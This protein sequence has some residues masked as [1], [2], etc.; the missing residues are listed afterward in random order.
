MSATLD[1]APSEAELARLYHELAKLGATSVGDNVPWVHAP[2]NRE[3][4]LVLASQMMRYDPR[5]LSVLVQWFA[6]HYDMLNPLQLRRELRQVRWP[7]SLLVVLE[8]ARLDASDPELEAF[9]KYVS[10]GFQRV[11]PAERFF[12]ETERP[13]SRA[14]TRNLG[15]NLAPYARWGFIGQERPTIDPVSKRS[16]GRYDAQTRR[17]I[18]DDLIERYT[19]F[20]MADYLSAVDH[21]I[22]RQQALAD[23]RSYNVIAPSGGGRGARWRRVKKASS[24]KR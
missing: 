20:S 14:A 22:S 23:L 6:A 5:L 18:L 3:Q 8:F 7:Q 2:E 9:C 15:R 13:G 24:R 1:H 12:L 19:D 4:L 17:R 10:I 16:V 21:S 11:E